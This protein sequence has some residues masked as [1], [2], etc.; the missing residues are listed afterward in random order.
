MADNIL[1]FNE[2]NFQTEVL[3]STIPVVV[4]FWA[5]WCGPCRAMAPVLEQLAGAVG[6]SV[7]IGKVNVDNA[8]NIA[9]NYGISAIPTMI[10]FK[11]GQPQKKFVGLTPLQELQNAVNDVAGER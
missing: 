8:R 9:M 7:K 2:D 3:E 5:E 1:E 6:E 11:N 10:I 4:D